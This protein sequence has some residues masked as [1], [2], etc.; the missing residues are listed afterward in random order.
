MKNVNEE[1]YTKGNLKAAGGW[2]DKL[3]NELLGEPDYVKEHIMQP[4]RIIRRRTGSYLV[5]RVE[6]AEK[7]KAFKE[8]RRPVKAGSHRR[9]HG[10]EAPR[11]GVFYNV[12]HKRKS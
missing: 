11:E 9:K 12:F 5:S 6:A 2:T 3:I 7:T 8:G 4:G 10:G 1:Y